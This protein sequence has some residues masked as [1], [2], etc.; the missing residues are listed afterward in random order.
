MTDIMF[1]TVFV[2]LL[3]ASCIGLGYCLRILNARRNEPEHPSESL[4]SGTQWSDGYA[5]THT[6]PTEIIREVPDR[7]QSERIKALQ[8]ERDGIVD[9][10]V[11]AY[12]LSETDR[13]RHHIRRVLETSDVHPLDP[14]AGDL[15]DEQRYDA[16]EHVL[17]DRTENEHV[18]AQL[19]RVGWIDRRGD[20]VLRPA[21]VAV[22]TT[23]RSLGRAPQE[24]IR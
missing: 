18:I 9:G 8:G 4:Y 22:W 17:T 6:R 3:G 23:D 24:T 21:E 13:S 2:L 11:R 5:N 7:K 14:E 1:R 12:N 15:F 10:L 16:V 20:R 19:I